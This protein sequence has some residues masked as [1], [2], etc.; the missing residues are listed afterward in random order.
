[1]V[2]G[3]QEHIMMAP[4]CTGQMIPLA[5]TTKEGV[6]KAKV[7]Q[8]VETLVKNHKVYFEL[9]EYKLVGTLE[10]FEPIFSTLTM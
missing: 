4:D 2:T 8:L 3:D 6:E 9:R 7:R 10:T 1:M 5:Y